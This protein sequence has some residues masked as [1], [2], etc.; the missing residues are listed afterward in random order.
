ML[1]S[2]LYLIAGFALLILGGDLLVKGA[3]GLAGRFSVPPLVIGLTIVA[4]GTSAPELFVSLDAALSG[5]PG[6]A[7]GNVVGSNIANVLLVIGVPAL[8]SS[9]SP[10]ERGVRR[11][12]FAMLGATA[13]FLAI[14]WFTGTI[15]RINGA[16]LVALLLAYLVWQFIVARQSGRGADIVDESEV[17]ADGQSLGG[18]SLR[19]V[20]GLIGLPLGAHL[21]VSGASDIAL[22][23][24][25]PETIIGLTI[26]GIGTSLPELAT[27]V[28]AA[29][30]GHGAVAFGNVVGSNL[31]NLLLIMGVTGLVVPFEV[32]AR[33]IQVDMWVMAA[34]AI[35]LGLLVFG[36]VRMGKRYGLFLTASY[37]AYLYSL[38]AFG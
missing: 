24:G 15:S 6:I 33:I 8:I 20:A 18:I 22:S 13:L 38:F 1:S 26:V 4:F 27:S 7:I 32:D 2:Y 28:T 17:E 10:T 35:I 34:A 31:F 3:V 9:M 16:I 37:L 29:W 19:I 14:L 30:R 11:N 25:V 5:Q 23:W 36:R 21:T 12:T